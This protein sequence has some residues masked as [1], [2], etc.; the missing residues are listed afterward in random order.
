MVY[1]SRVGDVFALG[2]TSWKIEDITHDRV[3]VSPAF[4]QPGKLPFWKGDGLGRPVELGRALGALPPRT[5][6][7][8]RRR[9]PAA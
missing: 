3:L 1:E 5:G 2:A 6:R 8:G 7:H 4:G 9:H